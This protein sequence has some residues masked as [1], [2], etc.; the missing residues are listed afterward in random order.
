MVAR[1][2][3]YDDVYNF[4]DVRFHTT[5]RRRG[6]PPIGA[7]GMQT[8][9]NLKKRSTKAFQK[10]S[11]DSARSFLKTLRFVRFFFII[12]TIITLLVNWEQ[13]IR[14]YPVVL[15]DLPGLVQEVTKEKS[16]LVETQVMLR[17]RRV[18]KAHLDVPRNPLKPTTYTPPNPALAIPRN[19][20]TLLADIDKPLSPSDVPFFWHILKSGGTT[21]KDAAGMCLGKVE[22]SESGVLDGH[23]ADQALQKVHISGGSID[24]VNVDTTTSQGIQ[25]AI[26]MG[27]VESAMS[28]AIFS[29]LLHESSQLFNNTS[30]KGRAFCLFRHPVERAVS[31]F[32]Y[33]KQASWE[34]TFS[35]KLKKMT[36]EDYAL[37]EFAEHNWMTRFLTNEM[38]GMVT[39]HHLEIAKEILRRKVL[40]GLTIDMENSFER[41]GKYLGWNEDPLSK[42]Q[43]H[44]LKGYLAGGSNQNKHAI[45]EEATKG[46][47]ILRG[48][49]LLDLELY[50][51]VLQLYHEQGKVLGF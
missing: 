14:T 46:W 50:D 11:R 2:E 37:S 15:A 44:C 8:S 21:I 31:L 25:R 42:D 43:K 34:P 4:P 39:T 49:N 40:V 19:L 41:F 30:H 1:E 12:G 5:T 33:L 26:S 9:A 48:N 6:S 10:E 20:D 13:T 32:H 45:A 17:L 24:Y 23:R 35:E 47:R 28:D 29:P 27:L 36:L 18:R 16:D 51:Y 38:T 7:I 22:A 3:N